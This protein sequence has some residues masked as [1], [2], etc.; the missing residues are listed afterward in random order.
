MNKK[1][2]L[3]AA[4]T[5]MSSAAIA[6]QPIYTE[7]PK[8]DARLQQVVE[9]NELLKADH[10]GRFS[11][12]KVTPQETIDV[13]INA[14]DANALAGELTDESLF[15]S[16]ITNTVLTASVPVGR[17]AEL[18]ERA[19]VWYI[20]SPRTFRAKMETTR[21]KTKADKVQA[22]EGLET[23]F[24][25]SGVLVAV[26]DQGFQP[27]HIAF[28]NPDG[29]SRV[30]QYWN[31][32]NYSYQKNTKPQSSVP[33]GGDG[34]PAYG[35][36][37]HVTNIAAG[38]DL[39]Q[40]SGVSKANKLYGIA[41]KADL[42]LIPSSFDE[43]EMI[44]DI[45]TIA[46][47][48]KAQGQPYVIN[49]SLGSQMGPHDGTTVYDQTC[50]EVLKQGSGFIC[51]AMGN[52]GGQRIHASNTF[53]A[54]QTK[55]VL[56][57]PA[58]DA[59]AIMMQIWETAGDGNQHVT[60]KP[61]YVLSSGGTRTYL[62]KQQMNSLGISEGIDPY[63]SRHNLQALCYL[64]TFKSIC[65]STAKLGVEM[66]GEEGAEIH[67]WV[68]ADMG[69]FASGSGYLTGDDDY[70]VSEGGASIPQA[71]GIAAYNGTNRFTSAIDGGTYG[72]YDTVGA[73]S[74]FSSPGPWLGT[75]PR[76]TVAAPGNFVQS[77]FNSYDS[78]FE[79]SD[80][81]IT[82]IITNGSTKYYYGQMT[83][84]SMAT[85]VASG[86]IALWLQANPDLTY[87]QMLNIFQSYSLHDNF[88]KS[89]Y[90]PAYGYG[91][92]DAYEGIKRALEYK[93]TGISDVLVGSETPV[94]LKKEANQ[95]RILF[96]NNESKASISL[97]SA[98][99]RRISCRNLAGVRCGQEE[100]ISLQG[101][102]AGVYVL[103]IK[104]PKANYDR[105]VVVR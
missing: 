100:T 82:S 7:G 57:T 76:P 75:E 55:S 14:K 61:F 35:H 72:S 84:T 58:S 67:A 43:A 88:T 77:A 11:L 56:Y 96:N 81:S 99:G 41:P 92:I 89:A 91:K 8:L 73:I 74:G 3:I 13:I 62:T 36:A 86:V 15:N 97:T 103:N 50:N 42:Y 37:T 64:S 34:I 49:L 83:G 23:P 66:T 70:L 27:R 39:S 33:N 63:N 40:F 101:L 22:G 24:D 16:V 6:Q 71:F 25:G 46:S 19:D 104:T 32:K 54:N 52:E 1:T 93:A 68:E 98:G 85:P 59:D 10:K 47:Y 26:I 87:E 45:Q 21:S 12:R 28:L 29:T 94:T 69:S 20:Q 95:W 79:T 31:R 30:K 9:K 78:Y 17:L 105:K 51:A 5:L 18:A 60:F 4:L 90:D 48:A 44:Q 53:T 38:S 102:P 80:K 2:I 65:G